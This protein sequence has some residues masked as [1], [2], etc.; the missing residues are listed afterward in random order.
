MK[1]L[2]IQLWNIVVK[3]R[4]R[5]VYC[6]LALFIGQICFF[7]LGGIWGEVYAA[8]SGNTP[9]QN[10]SFQWKVSGRYETVSF[11]QKM[12]YVLIYPLLIVA[13]KLVDNSF[14]YWEVFWF[15]AILWQLWI[16][17][18]NLSNYALGFLFLYYIFK[19]LLSGEKKNDPKWIIVRSLIAWVWI[20]ASWFLMVVLIDLSTILTYSIWWLPLTVLWSRSDGDTKKY[21][22]YVL[23][24][25]FSVNSRDVDSIDTYLTTVGTWWWRFYISECETANYPVA[26]GKEELL[27][28]PKMIYYKDEKN[29]YSK[30]ENNK[31]HYYGQVYWF[32]APL[33]WFEA[34]SDDNCKTKQDKYK[35]DLGNLVHGI[36]WSGSYTF[37][38]VKSYI[39]GGRLLQIWDAH[40]TWW[41]IGMDNFNVLYTSEDYWFDK[42]NERTLSWDETSRLSKVIKWDSYVW[43]FTSLYSSLLNAWEGI[44]VNKDSVY[45]WFLSVALAFLH[46]V[47]V[48]IPLIAM[49]IV[50]LMRIGVIWM[51]IALSPAIIL[52]R[53]FELDDKVFKK[54]SILESLSLKNLIPIIFSPAIICFAISMTTVLVRLIESMNYTWIATKEEPILWWLIKVNIWGMWISIWKLI[55]AVMWVAITWFLLWWALWLSKLWSSKFIQSLKELSTNALSSVPIIPIPTRDGAWTVVSYGWL[56]KWIDSVSS[57][58]ETKVAQQDTSAIEAWLN[59]WEDKVKAEQLQVGS[60]VDALSKNIPS[61]SNWI[62]LPVKLWEE[63]NE[64]DFI[65]DNFSQN[66]KE[67]IINA[68]N[69][70]KPA[71]REKFQWVKSIEIWNKKYVLNTT[72]AEDDKY[73]YVPEQLQESQKSSWN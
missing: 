13:W 8:D 7:N 46:M 39:E 31:C 11:L 71:E 22:P 12:V 6:L 47:A 2:C 58:L 19:Y 56:K 66:Q 26:S 36:E 15:D 30:T 18:R 49:S 32:S 27:V 9:T 68:I 10:A 54:D 45:L 34:C 41:I 4:K 57:N 43:V 73:K 16:V 33:I 42:N 60:Y 37:D 59:P 65:F 40:T 35:E 23:K 28:A 52:L 5:L 21:D 62:E 51:A 3:N 72:G 64:T 29:N 25:V 20:Q 63:W 53:V 44:L 69:K 70:L 1:K 50:F 38:V 17:V 55:V 48:A 14:V 67:Q 61:G 24:T